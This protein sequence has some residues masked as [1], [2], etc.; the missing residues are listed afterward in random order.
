MF[1]EA[2]WA[3]LHDDAETYVLDMP[4]PVKYLP[5]MSAYRVIERDIQSAIFK[6]HGLIGE[7]PPSIKEL[8]KRMVAAEGKVLFPTFNHPA[9]QDAIDDGVDISDLIVKPY[10]RMADAEKYYLKLYNELF[11]E[12]GLPHKRPKSR[13]ERRS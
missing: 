13:N 12:N 1:E 9:Y 11:D 4:R 6:K 10:R 2:C 5:Q 3:L 8:D 7:I